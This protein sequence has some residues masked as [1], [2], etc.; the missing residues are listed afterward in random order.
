MM[1]DYRKMYYIVANAA[2]DAIDA[3]PDAARLILTRALEQAEEV[4]IATCEE[5]ETPPA[6][7]KIVP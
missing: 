5:E 2:S 7:K 1:T 4:Y 6:G 3:P